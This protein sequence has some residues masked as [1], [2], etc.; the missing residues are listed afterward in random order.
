LV[1]ARSWVSQGSQGSL[2][3][4]VATRPEL[5]H[6]YVLCPVLPTRREGCFADTA[7]GH[8]AVCVRRPP[9]LCDQRP[10][11]VPLIPVTDSPTPSAPPMHDVGRWRCTLHRH[12]PGS[13]MDGSSVAPTRVPLCASPHYV[14][15]HTMFR[16][17]SWCHPLPYWYQC[18]TLCNLALTANCESRTGGRVWARPLRCRTVRSVPRAQWWPGWWSWRWLQRWWRAKPGRCRPRRARRR[19]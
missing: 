18:T 19:W 5:L 17:A 13:V 16:P 9:C 10:E 14:R 8:G 15:P 12:A 1:W 6:R 2:C 3:A 11:R 7:E 4:S